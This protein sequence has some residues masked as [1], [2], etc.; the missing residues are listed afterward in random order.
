MS[1]GAVVILS[2]LLVL[3][4]V[5]S[6]SAQLDPQALPGIFRDILRRHIPPPDVRHEQQ[7]APEVAEPSTSSRN[8]LSSHP[9]FDCAKARSIV[10]Q[11]I[12]SGEDGARA[13]WEMSAT[14]WA[15]VAAQ[16]E[17]AQKR[18]WDE[19]DLWLKSLT[20]TCKLIAQISTSQR[21]CVIDAYRQRTKQLQS[22]LSADALA[23]ARLSP[24]QRAAIQTQL[25]SQGY[26]EAEADGE[27]GPKTR[28]A[29]KRYLQSVGRPVSTYLG[30][31][32]RNSLLVPPRQAAQA[33]GDQ[34][35]FL[36][37][38]SPAPV[39]PQAPPP[40]GGFSDL[41]KLVEIPRSCLAAREL[42]R[43]GRDSAQQA[44]IA[45]GDCAITL[46]TR[47]PAVAQYFQANPQFLQN[48]RRFP[49]AIKGLDN[50]TKFFAGRPA[51]DC[52]YMFMS[53]SQWAF[54]F[55]SDSNTKVGFETFSDQINALIQTIRSDYASDLGKYKDWLPYAKLYARAN[56]YSRVRTEYELSYNTS[57]MESFLRL[58]EEFE[59]QRA[60][61]DSYRATLLRQTEQLAA[62]KSQFSDLVRSMRQPPLAQLVDD[63]LIADS[64]SIQVETEALHNIPAAE[65]GEASDRIAEFTDKKQRI[66]KKVDAAIRREAK[67]ETAV[68]LTTNTL[69]EIDGAKL[70]L[71]P[72]G[73]EIVENLR[74]TLPKISGPEAQRSDVS[75]EIAV[76][77]KF[78][79]QYRSLK[80]GAALVEE[81]V[82]RLNLLDNNID[83]R[84]RRFLDA[85]ATVSIAALKRE[86]DRFLAIAF[87]LETADAENLARQMK[88]LKQ[89]EDGLP[90]RMDVQERK[91]L[92]SSFPISRGGWTFQ[93]RSD[94]LTDEQSIVGAFQT[95]GDDAR[96]K[97]EI[98]CAKGSLELIVS[99]FEENGEGKSI[100][101]DRISGASMVRTRIDSEPAQA[102]ILLRDGY[103]NVGRT[104]FANL[105]LVQSERLVLGDVFPKDQLEIPTR[106]PDAVKR[107]C[108][109]LVNP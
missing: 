1:R 45:L 93:F 99:T 44:C 31:T 78:L 15:Y 91:A 89:L 40:V 66:E 42:R 41:E 20:K 16:D 57:D 24:E 63:D 53:A 90:S 59:R 98:S 49:E 19:Q 68:K 56:E 71:S 11:I 108:E 29:I 13:D 28:E 37:A 86:R 60:R 52:Q 95:K 23:E 21:A 35:P 12:C 97:I 17:S 109:L 14:T 47:I 50:A 67:R 103:T 61:A 38:S 104:G 82:S 106:F 5:T 80:A 96:Y 58:K 6:V 88:T 8:A 84:G 100:P 81:F 64:A 75:S 74:L 94:K 4:S 62:L 105:S 3:A 55:R 79:E 69:S 76:T 34:K 46:Q 22:K 70:R 10:S 101:W 54:N 83:K 77:D 9:T 43:G 73:A 39:Q 30:S 7:R 107:L 33:K 48:V 72:R 18:L 65:R 25:I 51:S 92:A 102:H 87:P 36:E 26:L 2:Q 85:D 27:F 32:E